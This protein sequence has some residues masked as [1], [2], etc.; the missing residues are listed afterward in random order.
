MRS[1]H[2]SVWPKSAASGRVQSRTEQK[3]GPRG[4][5]PRR[6]GGKWCFW[7]PSR[8]RGPCFPSSV[9]LSWRQRPRGPCVPA[10]T[11]SRSAFSSRA[12]FCTSGLSLGS[13]RLHLDVLRA[14]PLLRTKTQSHPCTALPLWLF[15]VLYT[16]VLGRTSESPTLA[17]HG[18]SAHLS[19]PCKAL[20]SPSRFRNGFFPASPMTNYFC[21]MQLLLYDLQLT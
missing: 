1:G 16:S 10:P 7:N 8:A 12:P 3:S 6:R 17:P 2:P 9:P 5:L 21:E 20:N 18:F 11:F 15:P 19:L 4:P 14:L 13:S